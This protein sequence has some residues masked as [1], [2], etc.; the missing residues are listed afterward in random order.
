MVGGCSFGSGVVC[1]LW[2]YSL[3][4]DHGALGS[5]LLAFDHATLGSGDGIKWG[6]SLLSGMG[7][8]SRD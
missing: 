2:E 5:D 6:P 7:V 8:F 4:W 3:G 1:F